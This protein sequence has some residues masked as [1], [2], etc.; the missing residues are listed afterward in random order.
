M[1]SFLYLESHGRE[2][3]IKNEIHYYSCAVEFR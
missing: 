3:S 1:A 2:V